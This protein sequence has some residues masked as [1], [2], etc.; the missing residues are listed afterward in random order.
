NEEAS[1]T[2]VDTFAILTT[3]PHQLM[4]QLHDRMPV[5]LPDAAIDRWLD[6]SNSDVRD[7]LTPYATDDLEAVAVSDYV[8]SAAH[9]GQ[10][11]LAP[12]VP[13]EGTVTVPNGT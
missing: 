1:D 11:C 5:V 4:Q 6:P 13:A 8:N 3:K 7:L 12:P 2:P 9:E 10:Q